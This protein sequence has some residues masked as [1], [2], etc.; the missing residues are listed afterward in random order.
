MFALCFHVDVPVLFTR[1][2]SVN[3]RWMQ[4]MAKTVAILNIAV[5][6]HVGPSWAHIPAAMIALIRE[7]VRIGY[8][9]ARS[10]RSF[11]TSAISAESLRL[12]RAVMP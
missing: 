7:M 5:T 3:S 1:R 9:F 10:A 8:L 2:R 6:A 12:Y 11:I 4:I